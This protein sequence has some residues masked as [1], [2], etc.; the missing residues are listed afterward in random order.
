MNK[1]VM[2]L[3]AL[4]IVA[5]GVLLWLYADTTY[6]IFY[7]I[8][9][10]VAVVVGVISYF[11]PT[12]TGMFATLSNWNRARRRY[13]RRMRALIRLARTSR[14][15]PDLPDPADVEAP[16]T[17][18]AWIYFVVL[19][20]VGFVFYRIGAEFLEVTPGGFN[21]GYIIWAIGVFYFAAGFRIVGPDMLT[22]LQFLGIPTIVVTGSPIIILPGLFTAE[23]FSRSTVQ[24]ELPDEPDKIFRRE[25]E[26]PVPEGMVPPIRVT[27]AQGTGAIADPLNERITAEVSVFVRFRLR[28]FWSFFVRIGNFKEAQRQLSDS[29]VSELQ[30]ELGKLTVAETFAKK[31]AIDDKLDNL[32]REKTKNWGIELIDVRIKLIGLSHE[33]NIS[34]RKVAQSVAD[35]KA[36]INNADAKAYDLTKVG[37]GEAKAIEAKLNAETTSLKKRAED[38]KVD[39]KNVLGARVAESIGTSPSSKIVLGVD[40]LVG[41][42]TKFAEH[43]AK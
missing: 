29:A 36:T 19:V 37:E 27:F 16:V 14:V 2:V 9:V 42:A 31:E 17:G 26:A 22:G 23:N 33:L 28:H 30:S 21:L 34:I 41:A 11:A 7:A 18:H 5:I 8:L 32:V 38:L 13:F 1:T 6:F 25:D 40:G 3:A 20:L 24:M 43:F 15:R 4:G 10:G 35:K 12:F 39:G